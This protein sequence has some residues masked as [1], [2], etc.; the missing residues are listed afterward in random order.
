M[1]ISNIFRKLSLYHII[2]F[3]VFI[4]FIGSLVADINKNKTKQPQPY[5]ETEIILKLRSVEQIEPYT[6]W[7]Y[8]IEL[9][10]KGEVSQLSLKYPAIYS[11]I[12]TDVYKIEF[13]TTDKGLLVIYDPQ[14]NDVVR[15]FNLL[16]FRQ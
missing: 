12:N 13:R 6:Y 1:N 9:L 3:V 2:F 16:D 7:N 15:I 10:E 4:L 5:N 11:G 8:T 14:K